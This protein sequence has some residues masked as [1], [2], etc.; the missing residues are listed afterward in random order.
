MGLFASDEQFEIKIHYISV[1]SKNGVETIRVLDERTEKGKDEVKSFG[2]K[3]LTLHTMWISPG[4]KQ[5][6]DMLRKCMRY[7]PES[8]KKELDWPLYRALIL[9]SFMKSW[10]AKDDGKPVDCSTDN[11]D[12]LDAQIAAALVDRFIDR[13]TVSEEDMGK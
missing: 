12:R 2:D 10:D 3:V 9:E 4:W 13:T 11:I 1:K 5:S 6:N 7:D 8:G